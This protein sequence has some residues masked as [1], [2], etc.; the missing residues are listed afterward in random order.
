MKVLLYIH[1]IDDV[2]IRDDMVSKKQEV[3][4]CQGWPLDLTLANTAVTLLL[5]YA[6][7]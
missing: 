7:L 5:T 4:L 1:I 3:E 2:K 6:Q